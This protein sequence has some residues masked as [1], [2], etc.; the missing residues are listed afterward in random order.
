[1]IEMFFSFFVFLSFFVIYIWSVTEIALKKQSYSFK[2]H[3]ILA[4]FL[5]ATMAMTV[6]FLLNK[7]LSWVYVGYSISMWLSALIN[8]K[9]FDK[10]LKAQ[11][12][13]GE[14]VQKR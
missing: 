8:S 6:L 2:L 7:E 12:S 11:L 5:L 9:I 13:N 4:M 3:S 1:M 10:Q 14:K